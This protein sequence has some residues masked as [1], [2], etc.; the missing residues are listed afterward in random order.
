M[1]H[2]T[3]RPVFRVLGTTDDVTTCELC[4]REDLRGTVVLETIDADGNGTGDLVHYGS[5]C[6]ARAAGW[7]T[8]EMGRRV[9]AANKAAHEA[10]M[11]ALNANVAARHAAYA[12][13][14][15]ATCGTA[16]RERATTLRGFSTPFAMWRHDRAAAAPGTA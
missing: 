4:G 16:D 2:T 14:L 6:G 9:T 1:A 5:D 12:A 7:T 13:Y 11:A 3:T 15:I 8:R 10:A